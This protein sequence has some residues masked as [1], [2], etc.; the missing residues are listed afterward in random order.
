MKRWPGKR[1]MTTKPW[2]GCSKGRIRPRASPKA[3]TAFSAR[4]E[5]PT[6]TDRTAPGSVR[7][8][9]ID[10]RSSLRRSRR[11]SQTNAN[12]AKE[13]SCTREMQ[14]SAC[15]I[16]TKSAIQEIDDHDRRRGG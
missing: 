8:D 10:S 5:E 13:Y 4:C 6:T 12:G 3:D 7:R 1:A 9:R 16:E 14:S 11:H 15:C 2:H